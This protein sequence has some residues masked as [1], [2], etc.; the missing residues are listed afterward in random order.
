MGHTV[1]YYSFHAEMF[2]LWYVGGVCCFV[3]TFG[4]HL[5]TVVT[6]CVERFCPSQL[7]GLFVLY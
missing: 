3:G 1:A 5:M 7:L 2:S 6:V 4:V